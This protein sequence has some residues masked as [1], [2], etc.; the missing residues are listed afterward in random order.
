MS[1]REPTNSL[2]HFRVAQALEDTFKRIEVPSYE[3]NEEL[4][5]NE[6][7]ACAHALYHWT[8]SND[9]QNASN[10]L[11]DFKH[12]YRLVC[13]TKLDGDYS[14]LIIDADKLYSKLLASPELKKEEQ[15][16]RT[17]L[18]ALRFAEKALMHDPRELAGQ[19]LGRIDRDDEDFKELLKDCNEWINSARTDGS[20]FL[21]FFLQSRRSQKF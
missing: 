15:K 2:H 13:Q 6:K 11:L 12:L 17:V 9:L 14:R 10:W 21:F 5:P 18:S 7:V 1:D 4:N 16:A 19:I 20:N 8:E 3:T